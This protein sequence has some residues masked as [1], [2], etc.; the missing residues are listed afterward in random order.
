[1]HHFL[2]RNKLFPVL[3]KVAINV[4]Y[5]DGASFVGIGH[6]HELTVK[7]SREFSFAIPNLGNVVEIAVD[8]GIPY[9]HNGHRCTNYSASALVPQFV[10]VLRQFYVLHGDPIATA[11]K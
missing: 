8:S 10:E 1:M 5:A 6:A 7:R 2:Y 11:M 9:L 4:H 3:R